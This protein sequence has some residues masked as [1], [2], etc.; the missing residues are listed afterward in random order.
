MKRS[1]FALSLLFGLATAAAASAALS[2]NLVSNGGGETGSAATSDAQVV[3]PAGWTTTGN[4]TA[5][6]YGSSGLPGVDS[7]TRRR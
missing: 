4:F 2:P 7:S 3:A 5:V 6:K 1:A